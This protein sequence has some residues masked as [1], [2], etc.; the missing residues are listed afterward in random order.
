MPFISN[1][2]KLAGG[3]GKLKLVR[4]LACSSDGE[5][6]DSIRH[7]CASMK[8]FI[9]HL[10]L[11][12]CLALYT[13]CSTATPPPKVPTAAVTPPV[14]KAAGTPHANLMRRFVDGWLNGNSPSPDF[15]QNN[16]NASWAWEPVGWV[17][18]ILGTLLTS[19]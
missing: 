18:E 1:S 6:G 4:Q 17:L 12:A 15:T 2:L 14:Q 8:R 10:L 9:V 13:G 5:G 16:D 7:Q 3:N 11:F 19:K